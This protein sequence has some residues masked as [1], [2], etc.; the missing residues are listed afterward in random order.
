M[1]TRATGTFEIDSWDEEHYDEREGTRLAR[2][3]VAKTFWGDVD[4][5]AVEEVVAAYDAVEGVV[6]REALEH[7]V[8]RRAPDQ[9]VARRA[10][11]PGRQGRSRE[12]HHEHRHHYRRPL[13]ALPLSPRPRPPGLPCD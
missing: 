8:P 13:H 9:V 3:R 11:E 7:V 1:T 12:G 5:L 4:Q 6:P 2:V 10:R